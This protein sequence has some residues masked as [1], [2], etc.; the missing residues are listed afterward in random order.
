MLREEGLDLFAVDRGMD[1]DIVT[2]LPVNGG[3]YAVLVTKLKSYMS[4]GKSK[5]RISRLGCSYSR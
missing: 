5:T 3:G 1:D 4:V 2:L